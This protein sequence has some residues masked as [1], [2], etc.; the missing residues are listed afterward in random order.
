MAS[1]SQANG[2]G[3]AEQDEPASAEEPE[4]TGFKAGYASTGRPPT[5]AVILQLGQAEAPAAATTQVPT[6]AETKE[7]GF[8]TRPSAKVST[9]PCFIAVAA[10][11]ARLQQKEEASLPSAAA[12]GTAPAHLLPRIS[13]K[14]GLITY[15][16]I[17]VISLPD[18]QS[19][20]ES[21]RLITKT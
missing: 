5:S 3:S 12:A 8:E 1:A 2:F 20:I 19:L 16:P 21:G 11:P 14:T 17:N 18:S 13:N 10:V 9:P 7:L 4:A 6:P 15:I